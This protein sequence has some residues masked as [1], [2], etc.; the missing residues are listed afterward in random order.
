MIDREFHERSVSLLC[1]FPA[2]RDIR[3]GLDDESDHLAEE[4]GPPSPER[5]VVK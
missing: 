4:S 2:E 3:A 1:L 5:L